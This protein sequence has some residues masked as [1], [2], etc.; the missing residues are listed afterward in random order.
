MLESTGRIIALEGEG[1]P[2][3]LV[4]CRRLPGLLQSHIRR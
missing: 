2:I 3:D 1:H 4:L